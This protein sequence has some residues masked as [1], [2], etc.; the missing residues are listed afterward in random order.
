MSRMMILLFA[1]GLAA[2]GCSGQ[3][4]SES[5]SESATEE[6]P[7][8]TAAETPKEPAPPANP[9][10]N[11]ASPEMNQTAPDTYKARFETSKG[12]FTIAVTR[13]WSPAGAD[14]FYNLVKNGYYTD[15]RFF[16]VMEGFMA[17]VGMHGDPNINAVW[18]NA[19][20]P[21]DP[22]KMGNKRGR[23]T[24]AK[25]G[26]PNSRTVQFFINFRDNDALDGQ[27]FAAFGEVVEGMDVVDALYAGYGEGAPRGNGPAQNQIAAGG[28]KFLIENFPQLDY[29]KSASIVE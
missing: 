13:D 16:R 5:A 10:L 26:S 1:L 3:G 12:A 18:S 9:L 2:A 17:Q 27:G 25:R 15:C 6:T 14:R 28:N 8:E 29:I 4:G 21:D 20:I 24:F 11:P 7:A 22:V 19:G 23:V